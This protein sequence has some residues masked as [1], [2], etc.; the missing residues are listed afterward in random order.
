MVEE[1]VEEE[2]REG[3]KVGKKA[4]RKGMEL[5]LSLLPSP[6]PLLLSPSS[7]ISSPLVIVLI[8]TDIAPAS[9]PHQVWESIYIYIIGR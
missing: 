5:P 1:E 4:G 8:G 6:S 9:L 3:L 2:E 7:P